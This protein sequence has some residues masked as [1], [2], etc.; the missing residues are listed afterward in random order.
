MRKLII[1]TALVCAVA[2]PAIAANLS[3]NGAST[4]TNSASTQSPQNLPS[5]IRSKLQQDGF[6]NVQIVPGSF[7]VS[8]K[9]KN[10]DP[11]NMVIGPNSMMMLTEVPNSSKSGSGT[12]GS[13][14]SQGSAGTT[15][16]S[17]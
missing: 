17:K 7:L 11:V 14:G 9:D 6:T 10:G 3:T 16:G 4:P 12:T 1:T 8:A 15:S 5:E 2:S 13:A